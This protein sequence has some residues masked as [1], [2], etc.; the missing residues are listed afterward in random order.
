MHLTILKS[1]QYI[2]S[3][4][5]LMLY[6]VRQIVNSFLLNVSLKSHRSDDLCSFIRYI[7]SEQL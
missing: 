2:L 7:Q 5:T 4:K 1:K 6:E 3:A